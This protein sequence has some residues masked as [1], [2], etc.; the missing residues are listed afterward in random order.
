MNPANP[1][2][3][4]LTTISYETEHEAYEAI[5]SLYQILNI[6]QQ[7][8]FI[9]R[10]RNFFQHFE[11]AFDN[12]NGAHGHENYHWESN[13]FSFAEDFFWVPYIHEHQALDV[14]YIYF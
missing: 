13:N 7:F 12:F 14:N 5:F 1:K 11:F 3:C 9:N 8:F 6:Q 10:M 4:V 2:N